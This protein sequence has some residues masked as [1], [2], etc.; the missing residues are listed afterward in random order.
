MQIR[1]TVVLAML[2]AAIACKRGEQPAAAKTTTQSQR[3]QSQQQPAARADV[4]AMMPA[5]AALNLDGSKFDLAS[6]RDKVVLL[7]VWAT[8]CG[9]CVYEIPELQ[10]LHEKYASRGMEVIGVSVDTVPAESVREFIAE[11]KKMTYPVVLDADGK[12]AD[13][14]QT[15]VLPTSVIIDRAGKIVWK[16]Y[17]AIMPGD[18]ELTKAIDAAL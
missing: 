4:G 7:N 15:S 17:G 11:Q 14:L 5:Y 10:Q 1:T 8:W 3:Q 13:M 18:E 16:Q 12:I 2:L 6:K 9:P